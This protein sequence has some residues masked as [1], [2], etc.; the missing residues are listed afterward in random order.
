MLFFERFDD[1]KL[2]VKLLLPA[3]TRTEEYYRTEAAKLNRFCSTKDESV[4]DVVL[5][6]LTREQLEEELLPL[7]INRLGIDRS[8]RFKLLVWRAEFDHGGE[9][10]GEAKPNSQETRNIRGVNCLFYLWLTNPAKRYLLPRVVFEHPFRIEAQNI[11]VDGGLKLTEARTVGNLEFWKW[12]DQVDAYKKVLE[13]EIANILSAGIADVRVEELRE[14][15]AWM[16][17]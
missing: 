8:L 12:P 11:R 17:V 14:A 9:R 15:M 7:G 1:P 2:I 5:S 13:Q 4:F 10:H 16:C 3:A 6:K